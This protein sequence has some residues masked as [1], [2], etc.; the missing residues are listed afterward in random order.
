LRIRFRD[1]HR[2][3]NV[4]LSFVF[5]IFHFQRARVTFGI[6][7]WMIFGGKWLIIRTMLDAQTPERTP[8]QKPKSP[9]AKSPKAT[10]TEKYQKAV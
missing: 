9:K 2:F 8:P 3:V 5:C 10:K 1:F 6:L 4:S 7:G